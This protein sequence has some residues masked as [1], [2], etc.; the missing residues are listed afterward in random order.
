MFCAGFFLSLFS[1]FPKGISGIPFIYFSVCGKGGEIMEI[2]CFEHV[3]RIQFNALMMFVIKC[4]VKNKK[5]QFARRSKR[6]VL[7]CELSDTKQL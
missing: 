6:E 4:T 1:A 2:S 5:R 7:F 3:V